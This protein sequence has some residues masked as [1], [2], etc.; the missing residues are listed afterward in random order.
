MRNAVEDIE[1][2]HARRS[3]S[4]AQIRRLLEALDESDRVEESS[5]LAAV[6]ALMEKG[7]TVEEL[8]GIVDDVAARSIDLSASVAGSGPL[9]DISGS[10]GDLIDTPNV[11]SLASFVVAAGGLPVAKQATRSFTGLTGSADVFALFGLD[12]MTASLKHTV[13]LLHSTKVTA[14]HT[15]SH[16]DRFARRMAV[17]GKMRELDL[18]I[19]TPWH[20]AAW[21]YSP[22]PLTGRVYGVFD[23]HYRQHVAEVMKRRFPGQHTLVVRGRDGIDEISV[24]GVTD[25]TEIREGR[26]IDFTL[27]PASLGLPAFGIAEVSMYEPEDFRR[28]SSPGLTPGERS[29]IRRRTAERMPEQVISILRGRGRPAHEALIAANAGAAFY[30]GGLVDSLKAG[31]SLASALLR[32]GSVW[33]QVS[34]FASA[35]AAEAVRESRSPGRSDSHLS[36]PVPV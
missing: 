6:V 4:N 7:L 25:V 13:S 5:Y 30:V 15:P 29:A 26:R 17:L 12:V 23:E 20:L 33:R 34:E 31:T 14:I 9:I 18:R 28:L 36:I 3:L 24:C 22:F 8:G 21:I 32:D 1:H 11:G 19:V 2:L 16:C 27:S 35:N 10:G